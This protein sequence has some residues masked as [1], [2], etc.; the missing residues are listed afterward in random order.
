MSKH[1]E[2]CERKEFSTTG[3]AQQACFPTFK[4]STITMRFKL[5]DDLR[6]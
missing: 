1:T 4:K 3:V 5:L 6:E 2:S